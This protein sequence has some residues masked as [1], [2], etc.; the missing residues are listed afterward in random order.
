M[1]NKLFIAFIFLTFFT[2]VNIN[3]QCPA[4]DIVLITQSDI[5]NFIANYPNCATIN[6]NLE[7]KGDGINDISGLSSLRVIN[8]E[9]KVIQTQI[10]DFTGLSF[11]TEI[12]N[13]YT[14]IRNNSSLTAVNLDN[15]VVFNS[16]LSING[17]SSLLS[18]SGFDNLT[19]LQSIE[20]SD[21]YSLIS[22]PLF[23][24]VVQTE[25]L[26]ITEN[27]SLVNISGFTQLTCVGDFMFHGNDVLETIP[28]F[29]NLKRV[30]GFSFRISYNPYLKSV[31]GF[32]SLEF[33]NNL[34]IIEAT[35]WQNDSMLI[36]DFP[37]LKEITG[38]LMLGS[39]VSNVNGF[40][41][42]EKVSNVKIDG[43]KATEIIG[44]ESLTEVL[45]I[46][47][48]DHIFHLERI[49]AFKNIQ[50]IQNKFRFWNNRV[51]NEIDGFQKLKTIGGEFNFDNQ[52]EITN[53]DFLGNLTSV[54]QSFCCARLTLSS[55]VMLSDCRAIALLMQFGELPS[56]VDVENNGAS[57]SS[58]IE[59]I[60]NADQDRDGVLNIVDQD[61]D[62]DGIYDV[63]ENDDIVDID[64]D[65]IPNSLDLNS[66][67]DGC[68]DVIEAGLDDDNN[69][70]IVGGTNVTVDANGLVTSSALAYLPPVDINGDSVYEFLDIAVSPIISEQPTSQSVTAG[71]NVTFSANIANADFFQWEIS[72]DLGA[73][74]E[75]L[76]SN[77]VFSGVDTNVLTLNT[78]S[79]A[80]DGAK[81][82]LRF[83]NT[84]SSCDEPLHTTTV[85]LEVI[86]TAINPGV[87]SSTF[88][89]PD[90]APFNL[91]DEIDGSPDP[92]GYWVPVLSSGSNIFDPA[93]DPPGTYR[94]Y[95]E[96]DNCVIVFSEITVNVENNN[97]GIDGS[98]TICET[99]SVINLFLS[100]GGSPDTGGSWSPALV[101]GTGMFN[102][103]LDIA[104][105]YTYTIGNATCGTV[106]AQ[107][108]VKI[109]ELPN[110]GT[111]GIISLCPSDVPVDLFDLLGDTPDVGGVWS[112]TLSSGTGLFNPNIDSG[113]TYTYTITDIVCG[114]VSSQVE[115]TLEAEPDAGLNGTLI[116]C[117]DSS[118]SDLFLS[119]E[120]SPDTGGEW[121]PA[122]ASGGG[123]FDP[124]VDL[125]GTYTYTVNNALC[126]SVSSEV[127]VQVDTMPNPGFDG[128][129]DF[130]LSSVPTDLFQFLNGTPDTGGVWSPSLNSGT[131]VFD[132][133]Q[134]TEGV[135]TYTVSNG[136][137]ETASATVVVIVNELTN[138]GTN[139]ALTICSLETPKDLFSLLGN[140]PQAGGVWSPMLASGT[141]IYNPQVD[142]P[143]TYTYIID[144]G[145]CGSVSSE[146]TVELFDTYEITNFEIQSSDFEGNNTARIIIN[147]PGEYMYS[148]DNIEFQSSNIFFN[149][150]GGDY[151]LYVKQ[152]DGCGY[153]EYEFSVLDFPKFF[154]PNNDGINDYWKLKGN[155]TRP[156]SVLIFDRYGKLLKFL[157]NSNE[158]WD[159][160]YNGNPMRADDYWFL[161]QF[162]DGKTKRG[163]FALVR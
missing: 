11:L 151:T 147:E 139:G 106:S 123:I 27:E 101:S 68:F 78:T 71:N 58:Q 41:K 37:E 131:G 108:E 87:N 144:G 156:Y 84:S 31:E 38:P 125:P 1:S 160:Y 150:G 40:N 49:D 116:L 17:N 43:T 10:A 24:Q 90:D 26:S 44:F 3:A 14:E 94:Y 20:I 56:I 159:G 48:E 8:G 74:W 146:V 162:E 25:V 13:G 50:L 149:L 75:D 5:D 132:P 158:F 135:Y 129:V 76:V 99:S 69:D 77:T 138:P 119:L 72:S 6:G 117:M 114:T 12:R 100:L 140:N 7:I 97:A 32:Q 46:E 109:N 57:C 107:V 28:K 2:C 79:L 61:D 148:I 137:C 21:N 66:D 29:N 126:G 33:V 16:Y 65:L 93:L 155:T 91:F 152:V 70:G 4:G 62:N 124:S 112:P 113:G 18:I 110:T 54:G 55:N 81:L 163:H 73:T 82:R 34:L 92:G 45:S 118:P 19:E 130:C 36:S 111:D 52:Y 95:L 83:L 85:S 141:G 115:V 60:D 47:I 136:V 53:L 35:G 102:P 96:S 89:C 128:N 30:S 134:D 122:L 127:V 104:G 22:I 59:I 88:S 103:T 153:L 23:D 121:S 142:P 67:N 105:I 63:L 145:V 120:G 161:I 39:G 51:L 157:K 143:G 86:N 80:Y 154:T 64:G 42:L 98:V 133:I 15:L 9:L